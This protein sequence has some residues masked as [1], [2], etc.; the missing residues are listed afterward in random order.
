MEKQSLECTNLP[1]VVELQ[2]RLEYLYTDSIKSIPS[3]CD[4]PVPSHN[5]NG[6]YDQEL[7]D[8]YAF[9]SALTLSNRNVIT[10][11]FLGIVQEIRV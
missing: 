10:D 9:Q 7:K 6:K 4:A 1:A 3:I 8:R 2:G 5:D 11:V